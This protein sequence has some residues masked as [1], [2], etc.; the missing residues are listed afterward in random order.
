LRRKSLTP[1]AGPIDADFQD[2]VQSEFTKMI[3]K[4]AQS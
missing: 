1:A 4:V 2:K 3:T